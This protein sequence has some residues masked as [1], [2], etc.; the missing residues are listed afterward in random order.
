MTIHNSQLITWLEGRTLS[1]GRTIGYWPFQEILREYADI[2]EDDSEGKARKKLEESVSALFPE[3]QAE[4]L[5]YLAT[6]LSLDVREEYLDRV[7]Y[8]DGEAMGQQILV[9]SRRFFER[10]ASKRPL[11][12]VFEDLHW[13][14]ASSAHLLESLLPL[15]ESNP[16][17]LCGLSRSDPQT[18]AGRLRVLAARDYAERYTEV[19][20]TPLSQA[21]SALLVQNLLAI[22]DLPARVRD[23]MVNKADGNPFFLE[24]IIR[25]MIE[26][27]AVVKDP[28][29]GRW[30]A[31]A[32]VE[33]A[34]IPDTIQGV[35]IARIDRLD[36]ELRSVLRTAAVIGRTFLYRVLES[37]LEAERALDRHLSDLQELELIREKQR[38]PEVEYIFKHALAQEATYET[39][40]LH[41]RRELHAR[42]ARAVEGLFG[43]RLDEFFGLLAY[44]YARAEEW[45]P[46]HHY[47]LK[48]GD[49][50]AGLAAGPEALAHYERALAAYVKVHGDRWD[51]AER[52]ALARK[53]AV[54]YHG[55][56]RLEESRAQF[57]QALDIV[58]FPMPAS[59]LGLIAGSARQILRQAM[60]RLLPTLFL[61]PAPDG[62]LPAIREATL[63][64]E[65]LSYLLYVGGEALATQFATLASANLAETLGPSPEMARGF[66]VMGVAAGWAGAHSVARFY[67]RRALEVAQMTEEPHALASVLEM[68]AVYH[69]GAGRWKEAMSD[70]KEAAGIHSQIGLLRSLEECLGTLAVA[71]YLQGRFSDAMRLGR[72]LSDSASER[73]DLQSELW[74]LCFEALGSLRLAAAADLVETHTLLERAQRRLE[75]YQRPVRPDH[76]LVHGALAQV[77]LRRG[78]E[79]LALE[80]AESAVGTIETTWWPNTFY[81]LEGYAGVPLV[82]LAVWEAG[83]RG[84]RLQES[85]RE[86][87]EL[88]EAGCKGLGRYARSFPHARPRALL[89][90]GWCDW[91]SGKEGR[92]Y[93]RWMESLTA[94]E[95]LAMPYEEG[96]AHREIGRR[97]PASDPGREEHLRRA[98]DIFNQLNAAWDL[99]RALEELAWV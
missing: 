70:G 72:R 53:M 26:A 1:F 30:R 84:G 68:K 58:G 80:A 15:V 82:A 5:P 90:Q 85:E 24:E 93:K 13:M 31:T 73:G 92:A 97:L 44:H 9:A 86:M 4:I 12:L 48:A 65:R 25:D 71:N 42:V 3:D 83:A 35:V 96:L 76:I 43:E 17:L 50:A 49:Q 7:K 54:V 99:E 62:R 6:L 20:L 87:R 16:L 77:H 34:T 67:L 59:R 79:S 14:D 33:T 60:R 66:S 57:K 81:N 61:R 23:A 27:G 18:P 46:A 11:V 74:G 36:E 89:Y 78:D 2:G 75:R 95:R 69:T 88:A 32:Q 91:L 63:A 28:G 19:Q 22:D 98:I 41:K 56:N 39:I 29:N 8:L 51:P 55:S 37:V 40:L 52:A 64:Y 38:L 47:L 45:E 10:L 94:A 21:N